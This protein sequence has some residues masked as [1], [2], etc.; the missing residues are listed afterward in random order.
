MHD[1]NTF[2]CTDGEIYLSGKDEKG[3]DITIVF[4]SYEFL[5]WINKDEINYIK[6]QTI[7]HIENL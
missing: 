3:D 6:T 2:H 1:I 7:K 5:T 4:S